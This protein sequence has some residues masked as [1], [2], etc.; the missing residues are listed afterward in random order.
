MWIIVMFTLLFYTPLKSNVP[1]CNELL[2]KAC[3]TWCD[4][5][6]EFVDAANVLSALPCA[7]FFDVQ[8]YWT[9]LQTC[10]S[11]VGCGTNNN[12]DRP[13]FHCGLP[14][15]IGLIEWQVQ[16]HTQKKMLYKNSFSFVLLFR[17]SGL[18]EWSELNNV[19]IVLSYSVW[20]WKIIALNCSF[21]ACFRCS[22]CKQ[23]VTAQV[24]L[25]KCS[26]FQAILTI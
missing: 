25:L 20:A 23:G 21:W 19:K 15:F 17:R 4:F 6:C 13:T 14:A 24:K 11:G 2:L 26:L 1:R 5:T 22:L 3:S 10:I 9:F 7:Q 18:N 8:R 12:V 16:T